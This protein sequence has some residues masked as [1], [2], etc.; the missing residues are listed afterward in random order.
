MT[1]L[2]ATLL[3]LT[4][5]V[6]LSV[7]AV[8]GTL[9]RRLPRW[10]LDGTAT[11]T[12][13]AVTVLC[14]F[15]AAGTAGGHVVSWVGG[16][17]PVHG[18]SV[19]VA[20]HADRLGAGLAVLAGILTIAALVFSWRYF[21]AVQGHFHA[22][23]LCFLA[24]M[25]GFTLSGDVF[26]MFVFFE[27]MGA[28]AY[29]LT[30]LRAEEP[31]PLQGALNF[32][33]VNSIGA[34]LTLTGIGVLYSRTGA[35]N[36][37]LLGRAVGTHTDALVVASLILIC[38]GWLVKASAVPFH[39]WTADAEAVA[40]TP[41]CVLFSGV[42]VELGVY[43]VGRI[44]WTIYS[45]AVPPHAMRLPLLVGGALT[46]LVGGVMCFAQHHVKR[47]LAFS[48]VAH[49]GLFLLGLAAL[50]AK[51]I[52]GAALYVA[53][54]AGA[55]GAL[56][57]GAGILLNRFGA[58]TE[59]ALF[60]RGR[61][62]GVLAAGF[63]V[64][65]LAL[66]ALPPFGTYLGKALSEESLTAV[67]APW[68]I[69]VFIV[70]SA[71]TGGAVLRAT[72]R[73][74]LGWGS[75]PPTDDSSAEGEDE[76]PEVDKPIGPRPWVM[77]TPMLGLLAGCLLVGVLPALH[78][79]VAEAAAAFVD[80]HAYAA[81]TLGGPVATAA[82]PPVETFTGAGL[83]SGFESAALALALAAS[84]LWRERIPELAR[85]VG[86]PLLTPLRVLRSLHTGHIG[87][88]VAWLLVGVTAY[89]GLLGLALRG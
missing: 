49:V 15:V 52:A 37:A 10:L 21:D 51:G 42:M 66:A 16:W 74:F 33:V 76:E 19:G 12:A 84:A 89:A 86:R 26:N 14:G 81:A 38:T 29:A 69:A 28:A 1:G 34:F 85:A 73:I 36:L 53:G 46:A 71:L 13:L 27:L 11:V 44:Y 83:A 45:A 5:A 63:V 79:G 31:G 40:P 3:P 70:T 47:L 88:Y 50:D 30:A 23:M 41:V 17:T 54:Q 59:G 32:G 78:H 4:V 62:A 43:A 24:G 67:G 56:F 68:V 75:P 87:D 9:G 58:I 7:A 64:G 6:P 55:K 35:L 82:A 65:G 57:L 39:F 80:P 25:V 77:L 61:P 20:M 48:T 72:G 18:Y 8:V 22:L 60:G 2:L